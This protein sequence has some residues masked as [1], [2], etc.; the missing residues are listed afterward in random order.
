MI[1]IKVISV[2]YPTSINNCDQLNDNI[3]VLVTLE[4][5]NSYCVTVATIDW[6]CSKVGQRY[7]PSGSPDIIVKELNCKLIEDAVNEY[8]EGDAYWLR[9]FSMSHGDEIPD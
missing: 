1:I 9:V 3:D 2:D 4:N 7:L 5:G 6:I 8:A